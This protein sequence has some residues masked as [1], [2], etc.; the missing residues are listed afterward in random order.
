MKLFFRNAF[1]FLMFL[2]LF[3]EIIARIFHISTDAPK[4]FK[5][6]NG[7]INYYPNQ[8]GYWDGGRHK[9]YINK[10]GYPGGNIP[11]NFNNL[12]LLVG[13]SYI[14]NFMNPDSCRQREYLSKLQPN[15]NFLESS[16]AGINLL[17]YFEYSKPL[18]GLN[19]VYKIIYVNSADFLNNVTRKRS[20]NGYKVNL[21]SNKIYY[22]KYR[23]SSLKDI[24]YN[25]KFIYYLYRKNIQLFNRLNGGKELSESNKIINRNASELS[26]ENLTQISDLLDFII[27]NYNCS[28]VV[29]VFHPDSNKDLINLSR[30]KGFITLELIK[31]KN[32]NWKT[33]NDGHWNCL[34]HQEIAKQV[35]LFINKISNKQS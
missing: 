35:S 16:M 22:P 11:K 34:A 2:F 10:L 12:V 24:I 3:T 14:Q 8:E 32:V 33:K 25:F 13:D 29:F 15:Y 6:S 9:W 28:N 31:D 7:N 19:P 18:D 4:T 1:L 26:S 23:G 17:G 21:K 30:S 27:Q 20:D 5:N